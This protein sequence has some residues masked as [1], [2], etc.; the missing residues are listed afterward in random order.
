M[1]YEVHMIIARERPSPFVIDDFI[2][3]TLLAMYMHKEHPKPS[4]SVPS[5]FQWRAGGD[6]SV[7]DN[8]V[9]VI[10]AIT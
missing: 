6:V 1:F 9:I 8:N 2:T 3:Y 5:I 4:I 10:K 7:N